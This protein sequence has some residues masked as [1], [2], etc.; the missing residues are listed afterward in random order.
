MDIEGCPRHSSASR[1]P[2]HLWHSAIGGRFSA[3]SGDNT[4]SRKR[5]RFP[6]H[7]AI[8][9]DAVVGDVMHNG[10]ASQEPQPR[11]AAR[12]MPFTRIRKRRKELTVTRYLA[13][14]AVIGALAPQCLQADVLLDESG[15]FTIDSQSETTRLTVEVDDTDK[16]LMLDTKV[17]LTEGKANVR[18]VAPD[19]ESIT[20]HGTSG[21]MSIG[22][23][24]IKTN[25]RTG[26]FEVHVV[27][28][29]ALGTGPCVSHSRR[30]RRLHRRSG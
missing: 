13:T 9:E 16:I 23:H 2:R 14:L 29:N 26:S 28:V 11:S 18:V 30:L 24:L 1:F 21:S 20:D 12:P 15:E 27:P 5:P 6:V 7:D 8:D 22:G 4:K 25:G 19:G 17:V 3:T 10:T